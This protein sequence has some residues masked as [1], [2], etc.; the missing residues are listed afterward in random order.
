ML[1]GNAK[2]LYQPLCYKYIILQ[3]DIFKTKNCQVCIKI[4]CIVFRKPN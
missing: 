3:K 1:N 2:S 4:Q